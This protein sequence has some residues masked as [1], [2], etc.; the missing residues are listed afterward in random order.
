M[1]SVLKYMGQIVS[2]SNGNPSSKR[3]IAF[4]CFVMYMIT[5]GANLFHG[6]SIDPI[7]FDS[8]MYLIMATLGITGLEKFAS[9]PSGEE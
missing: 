7:I 3:W 5:W 6:M 4:L 1:A 9:R 8:L 2:E